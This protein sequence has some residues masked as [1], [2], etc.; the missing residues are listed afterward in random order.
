[1]SGVARAGE[2]RVLQLPYG[3]EIRRPAGLLLRPAETVVS[4]L[5]G[6]DPSWQPFYGAAYSTTPDI[7]DPAPGASS[8]RSAPS[9]PKSPM[10]PRANPGWTSGHLRRERSPPVL[11][12]ARWADVAR[13]TRLRISPEV[14]LNRGLALQGDIFEASHTLQAQRT[15]QVPDRRGGPRRLRLAVYF[16]A[17]VAGPVGL[18]VGP[19]AAGRKEAS[20]HAE[21]PANG[22]QWTDS[23]SHRELIRA[24]YD[25]GWK[26][27]RELRF[28]FRGARTET[29]TGKQYVKSPGV[30]ESWSFAHDGIRL[31]GSPLFSGVAGTAAVPDAERSG[32][33]HPNLLL[34]G[35]DRGQIKVKFE[36]TAGAAAARAVKAKARR[37]CNAG[38]EGF[39]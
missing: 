10:C 21:R 17:Y 13:G 6:T 8:S 30:W 20:V 2:P 23:I 19:L 12:H 16:K 5:P 36:N 29:S 31:Y 3:G 27:T 32:V 4:D 14:G 33:R 39:A 28:V 25:R 24:G 9:G 11:H 26:L 38:S 34:T 18:G 1:M 35:R 22:L 7:A 37:S 15:G